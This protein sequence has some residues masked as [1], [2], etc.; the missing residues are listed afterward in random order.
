MTVTDGPA[1]PTTR[2]RC[3][4]GLVVLAVS[5]SF[6]VALWVVLWFQ[7]YSDAVPIHGPLSSEFS[8]GESFSC[9]PLA[10]APFAFSSPM[11]EVTVARQPCD[12]GRSRRLTVLAI[13]EGVAVVGAAVGVV[14]LLQ[15][16]RQGRP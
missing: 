10:D 11:G 12:N 6:G 15:A 1:L 14:I 9:P 2:R 3:T 5:A 16:R 4:A 7:S 13:G 8:V